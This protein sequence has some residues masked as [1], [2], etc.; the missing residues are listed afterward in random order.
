MCCFRLHFSDFNALFFQKI[1]NLLQFTFEKNNL[2][3]KKREKNNLSRG[4]I[5]APP[6]WISNGPSLTSNEKFG[7]PLI[8]SD[9]VQQYLKSIDVNKTTGDNKIS[10]RVLH[11]F[12]PVLA[13][14]LCK[15]I[16]KSISSGVFPSCWKSAK[17]IPLHKS[18][19]RDNVDNYRPI[20]ILPIASKIL[21]KHVHT[22]LS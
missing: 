3:C 22:S 21:E 9:L 1:K 12:G 10:A 2:L 5:P 16:N 8:S 4:K 11:D 15:I 6:P 17:V 13:Q 18:G 19:A 14:P 20:S 7:I